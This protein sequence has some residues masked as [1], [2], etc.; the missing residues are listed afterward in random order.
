MARNIFRTGRRIAY[1][2]ALV[3]AAAL[4]IA[5]LT[6]D[7]G[8]RADYLVLSPGVPPQKVDELSCTTFDREEAE[9]RTTA[10][11]TKVRLTM[12]FRAQRFDDGQM[13]VPYRSD[14][15]TMQGDQ[16]YSQ[17]VR[18]YVER[19]MR[20]FSL[21]KADEEAL[22]E[23]YWPSRL[24]LIRSAA[25]WLI[26]GWFALWLF[27]YCTGWVARRMSGIPSGQDG[28]ERTSRSRR[29]R[30]EHAIR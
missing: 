12:C 14:G 6:D 5:V 1:V 21:S 4:L 2:A 16:F 13:L 24:R 17:P 7:R 25:L 18:E 15:Q 19:R 9:D 28:W 23:Q 10:A 11:G 22:D 26:G 20:E 30:R 29:R 8:L 27:T 3:W